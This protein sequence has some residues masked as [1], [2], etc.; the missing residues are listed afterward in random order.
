VKRGPQPVVLIVDDDE[1]T[2]VLYTEF[3]RGEGFQSRVA[4][5]GFQA[6]EIATDLCPAVV[7][8]DLSMPRLNGWEATRK[9]KSG[10]T[11][12]DIPIIALTGHALDHHRSLA[13]AAGCDAFLTK[14]CRPDELLAE[15]RKLIR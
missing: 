14:P 2:R 8:M 15:I 9:L 12:G 5:D 10:A 4:E 11:T 1:E 13:L 6:V 7:V 3:L